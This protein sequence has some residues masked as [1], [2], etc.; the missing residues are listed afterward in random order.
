MGKDPDSIKAIL[1]SYKKDFDKIIQRSELLKRNTLLLKE[2]KGFRNR[3]GDT[4]FKVKDLHIERK[5]NESQDNLL[6]KLNYPVVDYTS[7]LRKKDVKRDRYWNNSINLDSPIYDKPANLKEEIFNRNEVLRKYKEKWEEFCE[8]WLIE[9]EWDGDFQTLEKYARKPVEIYSDWDYNIQQSS[10]M[11]RI[12]EWTTVDDIKARWTEVEELQNKIWGKRERRT[13]FS[14]DLIW[15]DLAKKHNMKAAGIAT[16]WIKNYPE[17]IDLLVIRRFRKDINPADLVGRGLD[18]KE[19][20]VEVKKGFLSSKYKASFEGELDFYI[21]GRIKKGTKYITIAK[22][23][24]D[25]IKKAIKRMEKQILQV[26]MPPLPEDRALFGL[27]P[28][29]IA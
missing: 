15:Y 12:N 9:P 22:P 2:Y 20:V 7:P 10:L 8:R 17:D 1:L 21:T 25:V 11:I 14:R 3:V 27:P 13:N 26:S 24:V 28:Q 4:F 5:E 16:L 19:L 29:R 23:I 6:L 18:D